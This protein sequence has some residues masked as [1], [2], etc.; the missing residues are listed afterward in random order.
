MDMGRKVIAVGDD[1]SLF[2]R[3]VCS[4]VIAI[5]DD[6]LAEMGVFGRKHQNIKGFMP[7]A[8]V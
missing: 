2:C 4:L 6:W 3:Y 8:P 7:L 1:E 5:H